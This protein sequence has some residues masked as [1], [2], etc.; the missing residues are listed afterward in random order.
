MLALLAAVAGAIVGATA[1]GADIEAGV[2]RDLAATGRS[3]TALFFARVPG[4]LGD[5]AS[6]HAAASP[7]PPSRAAVAGR[8]RGDV[9]GGVRPACSSRGALTAARVASAS[10]R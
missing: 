3:R 10:P 6:R 7:S 5:R 2:F 9:A 8:R 4:A 1:G